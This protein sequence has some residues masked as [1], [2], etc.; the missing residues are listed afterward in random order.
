[1]SIYS[2]RER[3]L[4]KSLYL[5]FSRHSNLMA[6]FDGFLRDSVRAMVAAIEVKDPYTHEH[7]WRVSEYALILGRGLKLSHDE[8][9]MLELGALLHDIGKIGVPDAVLIKPGKLTEDEYE[10][11]KKHPL[12]SAAIVSKI[13]WLADVVPI[14]KYHQERMD[15]LGYPAGLRGEE[16]P[17]FS[18]MVYVAD[19][20]DAM[21]SDR[22]YRKAMS[23]KEAFMELE[24]NAGK[25]FDSDLVKVFV[26]EYQKK[27]DTSRLSEFFP[28]HPQ[29]KRTKAVGG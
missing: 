25:Q 7:S 2:I 27:K 29:K 1:M 8:L 11:M 22:P 21:T 26:G 24:R 12:F 3:E 19:S 10:V 15:G 4:L 16:I 28:F 23:L 13:E 20:F 5:I 18:R 6:D 9:M 17:K 14:V